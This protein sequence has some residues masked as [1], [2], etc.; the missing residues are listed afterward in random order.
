MKITTN[1]SPQILQFGVSMIENDELY[2]SCMWGV[3]NLDL[4]NGIMSACT[5]CGDYAYRWPETDEMFLKLMATVD[6]EYLLRKIARRIEFDLEGTINII[7]DI[8]DDDEE[9]QNRLRKFF[10]DYDYVYDSNDFLSSIEEWDNDDLLADIDLYE[11]LVYD[12][13]PQ[14]KTFV[15]IFTEYIQPEIKKYLEKDKN[16]EL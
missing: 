6:S 7:I 4:K 2:H 13:H 12:Y 9:Y 11:C 16:N 14:A 8:F 5:D 1:N 15:K 10:T 3:V